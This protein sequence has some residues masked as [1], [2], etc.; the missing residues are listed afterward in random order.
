MKENITS[1]TFGSLT[2]ILAN[3]TGIGLIET[4]IMAF[5]GGLIGYL[6]NQAAKWVINK[7]KNK[8]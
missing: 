4:I 7:I 2:T 5:V 6:G 1:V 3:I 8:I